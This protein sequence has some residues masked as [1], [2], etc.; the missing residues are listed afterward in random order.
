MTQLNDKD[1][2]A[3]I[4]DMKSFDEEMPSIGSFLYNPQDHCLVDVDKKELTPRDVEEARA[5]GVDVI[6]YPMLNNTHYKQNLH[7]RVV[8]NINKFMVL[9][10]KW[11]E[12]VQDELTQLIEDTFHLPYFEFVYDEHWDLGHDWSADMPISR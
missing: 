1:R 6:N 11:A 7:G 10:G 4:A 2:A 3:L 12:P 5:E 9:V 8:W